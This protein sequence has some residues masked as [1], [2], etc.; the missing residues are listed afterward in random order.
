M[1]NKLRSLFI[2]IAALFA[3]NSCIGFSM[4]IQMNRDGSGR[5]TFEYR[6]S[7]L[8]ENLGKLDG[9]ESMPAIPVGKTD[10]ER[11]AERIGGI[12]LVSF[13]SK[14]E[15][16]DTVYKAVL[17]F[18]NEKALIEILDPSLEKVSVSR[19]GQSGRLDILLIDKLNN[20]DS[21]MIEL[22]SILSQDYEFS[23]S[24]SAPV[25]STLTLNDANGNN[26]TAVQNA[27]IIQTGKKVS[28]S[29]GILDFLELKNGIKMIF[30]W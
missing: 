13:S 4:D 3:F 25:N 2:L 28:F 27:R 16:K 15:K 17:D 30:N 18:D 20:F 21:D 9:N 24:F 7:R 22:I 12:R 6:L 29:I 23:V 10:W 1:K 8:I 26:L 14:D 5:V 11:T 19:Q